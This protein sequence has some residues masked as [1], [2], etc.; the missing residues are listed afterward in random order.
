MR[1]T[2]LAISAVLC[3]L[4]LCLLPVAGESA[5]QIHTAQRTF[6]ARF[7]SAV[8]QDSTDGPLPSRDPFEPDEVQPQPAA[9]RTAV[10]AVAV[11]AIVAGADPR[12]LIEEAGR[13]RIVQPGDTVRFS[14]VRSI[15]AQGIVLG[16][17]TK[18]MLEALP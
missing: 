17:G 18:L 15:S 8:P 7:A 11:R 1:G 12:A 14:T 4:G 6:D 5:L 13:M 10:A 16:D 9:A 3:A 2:L